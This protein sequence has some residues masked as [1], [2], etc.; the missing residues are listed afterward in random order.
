MDNIFRKESFKSLL[1]RIERCFETLQQERDNAREEAQKTHNAVRKE[2]ER[3]LEFLN[4]Q[5]DR[6]LCVMTEVEFSRYESFVA[7]HHRLHDNNESIFSESI[8]AHLTMNG[9]CTQTILECPICHEKED[10]TDVTSW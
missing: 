5:L 2:F 4:Q 1:E 3:E 10:I 6:A 8:T 7:K 9:I